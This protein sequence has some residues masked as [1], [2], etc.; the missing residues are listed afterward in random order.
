MNDDDLLWKKRFQT[1]AL[2]RL[3]GLALFLLG[4]AVMLTDLVRPGGWPLVGGILVAIGA[5]E[6]VVA[7]RLLKR[8]W[9]KK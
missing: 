3:A 9:D 5:I 7:P 4:M 8:S 2:V 6:A 1:F